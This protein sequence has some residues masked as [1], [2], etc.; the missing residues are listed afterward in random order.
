MI[1]ER[2]KYSVLPSSIIG[3]AMVVD[4][5]LNSVSDRSINQKNQ[6]NPVIIKNHSSDHHSSDK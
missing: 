2:P 1:K 4:S 5:Q 6:G 3:C